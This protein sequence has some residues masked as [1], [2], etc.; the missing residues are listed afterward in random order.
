MAQL[1]KDLANANI[2]TAPSPAT[3]GTSIVLASG[4]GAIFPEPPFYITAVD[5]NVLPTPSTAEILLVTGKS[6]DTLTV[7]RGQKGTTAKTIT[8]TWRVFNGI[9]RDDVQHYGGEMAQFC[10]TPN[11]DFYNNLHTGST[12]W[13]ANSGSVTH[14]TSIKK[15]G[16][17]SLKVTTNG[18]AQFEGGEYDL[19]GAPLDWTDKRFRIWVRS[20]NWSEV[21]LATILI[22]TSG[23]FDSFYFA[24][25]NLGISS[26]QNDEWVEVYLDAHN[27]EGSGTPDWSTANKIIFRA[28]DKGNEPVTVWY[29]GFGVFERGNA[30]YVSITFD[31]GWDTSYSNGVVG[32]LDRY[33]VRATHFIIPEILGE[34]DR[35]TQ[36]EVNNLHEMGHEISGHGAVSLVDLEISDG[37]EAVDDYVRYVRDW[38]SEHGYRGQDLW[39]Y[40]NGNYTAEIAEVVGRYFGVKRALGVC[41]QPTSAVNPLHVSSRTISGM[42]DTAAGINAEI[43]DAI[44]NQDWLILVFHKIPDAAPTVD[45][46]F[47]LTDLDTVIAHI[48]SSG[49]TCLPMG[50]VLRRLR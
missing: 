41:G 10:P 21:D 23:F 33:G 3:S 47:S 27:F 6:T 42:S 29:N 28:L 45:T 13:Y 36:D 22:S 11:F 30:G 38:T 7:V 8:N 5:N 9:Y 1:K 32:V 49:Y 4:Q 35:L 34:S 18:A 39:A 48:T 17:A 12:D 14:D 20:D 43:D 40:P 31:D 19:T 2:A 24:H 46:E 16:S 26:P 50:E 15:S 44:T 37:I 25:V